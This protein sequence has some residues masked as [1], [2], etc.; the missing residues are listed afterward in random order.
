LE[1][2]S[3]LESRVVLQSLTRE[4]SRAEPW[5]YIAESYVFE[6]VHNPS[7]EA[8]GVLWELGYVHARIAY[9]ATKLMLEAQAFMVRRDVYLW[10]AQLVYA[11]C[12]YH[13][14][15]NKEA[16]SLFKELLLLKH[17]PT[18]GDR[19]LVRQHIV[20]LQEEL[21]DQPSKEQRKDEN[22]GGGNQNPVREY[23]T[24]DTSLRDK[25][26]NVLH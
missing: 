23:E 26:R 1:V 12:A 21:H 24:S 5:F 2:L 13:T 7:V 25:S 8:A 14:S 10:R 11:L 19:V 22:G 18:G 20:S 17:G 6:A 16:L 15:R 3:P 9:L 4:S